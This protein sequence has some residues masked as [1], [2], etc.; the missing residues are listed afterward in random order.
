MSGLREDQLNRY[1]RNILLKGIGAEGQKR[2]LDSSVLVIGA[3]GLGSPVAYY[4]AAAG[5]GRIGLIDHDQV[6][7]SNLQRQ[8]LH[9]TEDLNRKKAESGGEKIKKLNPDI[10]VDICCEKFDK[11]NS[12]QLVRDYDV[13]VD[14]VDGLEGKYLINDTCLEERK[15]FVY[16]AVRSF[17]GQVATFIPGK[18]PCL[19]CLFPKDAVS[20]FVDAAASG[21]LGTVPGVIGCLQA[22][23]V[24]KILLNLGDPLVGNLLIYNALSMSFSKMPFGKNPEC[25]PACRAA[26]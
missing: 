18:G 13:V 24:I 16:G 12:R 5:V 23:E 3:G 2:L 6:N 22:T 25:I 19:R 4:L 14:C 11:R 7:L 10:R 15:P 1:E 21:V 8:I 26:D 17:T 9:F 20:V